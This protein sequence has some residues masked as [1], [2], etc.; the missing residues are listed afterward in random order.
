MPGID[1]TALN[2]K[3]GIKVISCCDLLG[4]LGTAGPDTTL[5]VGTTARFLDEEFSAAANWVNLKMNANDTVFHYMSMDEFMDA[6]LSKD[7][8]CQIEYQANNTGGANFTVAMKGLNVREI[9]SDASSSSDCSAIIA[10]NSAD[11]PTV[12]N[13]M[14]RTRWVTLGSGGLFSA[15]M[16]V[17][18][19]IIASTLSAP[20]TQ[21]GLTKVKFRY[22]RQICT[23]TGRAQST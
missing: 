13:Q 9:P 19:R 1:D 14:S 3:F 5:G 10:T 21:V 15:D 2:H 7:F 4:L 23:T 8:Q 20:T 12:A 17:Q 22:T 16:G 18:I 11:V 6:D